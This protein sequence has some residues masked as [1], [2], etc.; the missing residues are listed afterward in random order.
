MLT[1]A[2][3]TVKNVN[4]TVRTQLEVSG[5]YVTLALLS[6]LMEGHA[7]HKVIILCGFVIIWRL[8]QGPLVFYSDTF[9]K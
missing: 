4:I 6:S 9:L 7:L 2:K 5:V 8:N 1:N 3:Q